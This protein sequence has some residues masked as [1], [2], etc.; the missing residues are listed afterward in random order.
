[1][2]QGETAKETGG[3]GR[4]EEES[5][6]NDLEAVSSLSGE[7]GQEKGQEEKKV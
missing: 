7:E 1:M 4:M 5:S 3:E 2:E 6:N